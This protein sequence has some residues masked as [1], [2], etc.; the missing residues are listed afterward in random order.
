MPSFSQASLDALDTCDLRLQLIAREAIKY[1][2]F[3]VLKGHR[4]QAEQD[5]AF[6]AGTSKLRWPDG[7]HNKMPSLAMD[8]APVYFD[9]GARINWKDIPAF[10]RL[11]GYLERI[12]HEKGFT[13]RLGMDWDGDWRTAGHDPGENFLDAPHIEV[14]AVEQEPT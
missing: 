9:A 14:S 3:K 10:A 2:D 13:V 1:V 11:A 7:N 12:A 5:A 6:A 8:V 4:G